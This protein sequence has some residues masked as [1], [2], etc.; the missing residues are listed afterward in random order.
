MSRGSRWVTFDCYGTLVDWHG[1]LGDLLAPIAG[2]RA[3]EVAEAFAGCQLALEKQGPGRSHKQVLKAA[4][5]C[6][7]GERGVCLTDA[8]A[9]TLTRSW[10]A[11]RP[12]ADVETMLA[13]LRARGYRLGVLTNADDDLFEITHRSFATPFNL[14]VTA[15]RVRGYKPEPW[16]FR[17]FER[18][19]RVERGDWV[20]VGSDWYHDIAP[21][22][23]LGVP[24]VWLDRDGAAPSGAA[25]RAATGADVVR[26][27]D[28][29]FAH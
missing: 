9:R 7:A 26:A 27:I 16:L 24:R 25:L 5:L 18:L 14:F 15:E 20:H 13:A 6:A 12:F 23:A 10:S 19:T 4:L 21:A 28:R 29:H 2:E 1:G 17:A 22:Q 8:D 11:L 3:S